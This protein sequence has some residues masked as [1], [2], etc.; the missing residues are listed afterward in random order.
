MEHYPVSKSTSTSENNAVV[1][2]DCLALLTERNAPSSEAVTQWF[3]KGLKRLKTAVC[4]VVQCIIKTSQRCAVGALQQKENVVVAY[5]EHRSGYPP[6][7][8]VS[9]PCWFELM[10]QQ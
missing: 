4:G 8:L 6:C 7:F 1:M 10:A 2:D 3:G 9:S 5:V